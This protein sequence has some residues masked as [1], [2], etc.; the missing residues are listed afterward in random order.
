MLIRTIGFVVI[1]SLFF[2]AHLTC[3]AQ[4]HSTCTVPPIRL[5]PANLD[6]NKV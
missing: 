2:V 6:L 3:L 4:G 5:E 1:S